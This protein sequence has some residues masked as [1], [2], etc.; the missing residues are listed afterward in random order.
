MKIVKFFLNYKITRRL[1]DSMV[2]HYFLA[3]NIE[4]KYKID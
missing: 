4:I 2:K 3:R 1:I